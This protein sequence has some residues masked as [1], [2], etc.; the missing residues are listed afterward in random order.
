MKALFCT[1]I[2]PLFAGWALLSGTPPA[3]AVEWHGLLDMRALHT[4]AERSWTDAGLGKL[5]HDKQSSGLRLG[6]AFLSAQADLLSNTITGRLVLSAADDRA[7]AL[8]VNEA[9]LLWSPLP[10]SAW[11]TRVKL[12]AFFPA[13][14][15]ELDYDSIGWTPSRTVSSSA[16]N[17]WIG[18]E[19]RTQGAELTLTHKG[20]QS[21]SL[22]DF[23]L[24]L[25]VFGGNDPA[26]TL[27]GW[28]GWSISDRVSGLTE[29]LLLADLPV[30]RPSGEIPKQ[31]R[32][33]HL[34]RELDG[35]A[36]YYLGGQ[37][38]YT[39]QV[40]LSA[41]HYDNRGDPLVEKNG[42]YAWHTRFDHIG[43]R[44]RPAGEWELAAQLM[45]G[46]TLMGPQAVRLSFKAG[47]LLA[48]HP[49]AQGHLSLRYDRFRARENDILPSDPNHEDGRALALAYALPLRQGWSLLGEWLVV[50]STRPARR[51]TGNAPAQTERSL[52][53]SLRWQF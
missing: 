18:E 24:T 34:F 46:E 12:G 47:Y 10:S 13:S 21:N 9:W 38:A 25:A 48:S 16:V 30:Y 28:R 40:E 52:T 42:Q 51:L 53:A 44:L 11:K 6:Q 22:H 20:R 15:L 8:D 49:F 1:A 3:A 50:K 39:E 37:Y 41:L 45:S 7:G 26:G 4:D 17:S 19:L 31:N 29:G 2:A 35:R 27:M 23:G 32:S 36:G 33:V 43:L 14:S 5:R